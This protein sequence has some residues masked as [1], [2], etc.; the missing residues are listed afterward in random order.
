MKK[1]STISIV[2]L[3]F[4]FASCSKNFLKSYDKRIVGTWKINYVNNIGLG[5]NSSNL[6]FNNGTFTFLANGNL[7]YTNSANE[8]FKGNWDIV[9]KM[10]GDQTVR[11]L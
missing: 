3:I 9:K 8:T 2:A 10:Q 4:I 5:G 7:E 11:S 1:I 6:P